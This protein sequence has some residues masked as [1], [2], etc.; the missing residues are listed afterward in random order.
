[1]FKIRRLPGALIALSIALAPALVSAPARADDAADSLPETVSADILPTPQINGVV[2]DQQVVGDVVYVVGDFTRARPFGSAAGEN[3]VERDNALAYDINTGEL[4]SWAPKTNAPIMSI[5]ASSDGSMLYVGGQFTKLNGDNTWYVGAV[6]PDGTKKAL[7]AAA[8][9]RVNTVALSADGSTLYLGGTFTQVNSEARERL[10]SLD[11]TT[12]QLGS[13]SETIPDYSVRSIAAEPDGSGIAVGGSFTSVN[14]SSDPGYGLVI[15]NSDGSVREN[16]INKEVRNANLLG[17]IMDLEADDTGVYGVGYSQNSGQ[18]NIEGAF[19]ADWSSGDLD[20]LADCHGDNYDIYPTTDVV[21]VAGHTHDCTNIGGLSNSYTLYHFGV[22]YTNYA[23]GTVAKNPFSGYA[24]HAGQPAPTNLNFYPDFTAGT[25]TGK[26]QANWTVEGNDKYVVYG[27]EFTAVNGTPQ[28]GLTRFARRDIAT[29]KQG[30]ELSGS[31]YPVTATSP[32]SGVVHLAFSTNWDEDDKTLTYKV[33]RDS[34][35]SDPIW[36]KDVTAGYWEHPD[37][38]VADS[39]D[40]GSSHQYIVTVSDPWGNTVQSDWVSVTAASSG[41]LSDYEQSVL[42]DGGTHLWSYDETDGATAADVIG[43]T[44]MS[45][46]GDAYARGTEGVITGKAALTLASTSTDHTFATQT[47]A[48]A[49]PVTF[50]EE[51]WFRTSSTTGGEIMGFSSKD[52][53]D[54]ARRDRV[55]GMA[56]DGTLTFM[57]YIGGVRT[58]TTGGSYNDGQWHHV[59]ASLS[60][61]G[62]ASLYVDGSLEASDATLLRAQDYDG[63]WRVG[64]DGVTGAT[65]KAA[66][67]FLAGDI[68][69]AAVY[70]TVL[71]SDTVAAHYALGHRGGTANKAPTASATATVSDLTATFD[72]TASKDSDGS[73]ASYAWDFGD[74]STGTGTT[75]SHTYA[76]SGD[77]TVTLT[78]TDNEG[79]TAT[80]TVSVKATEPLLTDTFTRTASGS[81]G[82][83]DSGAVWTGSYGRGAQSV[84]GSAG[85]LTLSAPGASTAV[86][87]GALS[88]A[89]TDA[90]MTLQVDRLATG[91]GTYVAYV[92]RSTS[93]GRYQVTARFTSS[94]AVVLTAL[95]HVNG[96]SDVSLGTARLDG[97]YTAGDVLHLRVQAEGTGPTELRVRAWTGDDEPTAWAIDATDDDTAL[98]GAGAVGVTA[99]RSSQG[100]AD[101]V[102]VRLDDLVVRA[103]D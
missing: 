84:D 58:I 38:V 65:E 40:P 85:V 8:N 81:W 59:V 68:D 51:A 62:G 88:E 49:A 25:Y 102:T 55:V 101:P 29:N 54:G 89:S 13:L 39:V 63:Y 77:Y 45:V 75:A 34:T 17:G 78:V 27:G 3:E 30:P 61:T 11:V 22:A 4:L 41:T 47:T 90:T 71:S 35:D 103:L 19:K 37:L 93:A 10:A 16:D 15:I 86:T 79:A 95:K 72:G 76:A 5:T 96:A 2:W 80:T 14:G 73:I 7:R 26:H 52:D 24:N 48:S 46:V 97:T 69:E 18:A 57:T 9:G 66:T 83:S 82:T 36:T 33:Y 70:P 23:T 32:E 98:A 50:S 94:G 28:Q 42:D 56:S 44:D 99:Y 6:R 60:P 91:S 67:S 21:Y 12:N 100:D 20:W 53:G 1:M 43:G 87:T 31:N 64:G 74:G 92:A